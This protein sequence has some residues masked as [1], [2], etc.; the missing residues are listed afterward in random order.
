MRKNWSSGWLQVVRVSSGTVTSNVARA[1]S[2]SE[3][4]VCFCGN[5]RNIVV[6]LGR[7]ASFSATFR[8][9]EEV[10]CSRHATNTCMHDKCM[11]YGRSVDYQVRGLNIFLYVFHR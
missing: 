3:L 10:V 1:T 2:I 7:V 8:N 11:D 6:Y 5:V 4:S 9:K